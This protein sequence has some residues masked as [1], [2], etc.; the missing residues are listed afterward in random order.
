MAEAIFKNLTAANMRIGTIDS[1]GVGID[2]WL[3]PTDQRTVFTLYYH[4]IDVPKRQPRKVDASD[5][6]KFDYMLA[7][8]RLT[9]SELEKRRDSLR[10]ATGL[11]EIRLF[12][13]FAGDPEADVRDPFFQGFDAFESCYQDLV[14]FSNAFLNTV[15]GTRS[16]DETGSRF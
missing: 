4:Q 7:M 13:G 16:E 6:L 5:F 10:G 14:A 8:D 9:V 15:M 3:K 1:A 12:G 2:F 11:A